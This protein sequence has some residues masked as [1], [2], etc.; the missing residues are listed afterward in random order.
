MK[1][2]FSDPY[3]FLTNTTGGYRV[4]DR[5]KSEDFF[6]YSSIQSEKL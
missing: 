1:Y 4:H 5:Q 2:F 3:K 6:G